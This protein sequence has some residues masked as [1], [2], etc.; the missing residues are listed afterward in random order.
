MRAVV[1]HIWGRGTFGYES[2]PH[3]GMD[4]CFLYCRK[5]EVPAVLRA[6]GLDPGPGI[7][8]ASTGLNVSELEGEGLLGQ[9]GRQIMM[10]WAMEAFT[11]PE[12]IDNSI[13]Y[14]ER[15]DMFH[16]RFLQGFRMINIGLLRD[17]DL[18][19]IGSRILRPVSNGTA[20]QRANTY[21][22]RTPDYMI[23]TS[24]AYHPGTFGDQQ[25]IWTAT[26]SEEVSLFTTHPAK[27]FRIGDTI[28]N[29]PGYWVGNGRLPHCVQHKN[30]VLCMYALDDGLGLLEPEVA[31]FTHAYFPMD[32][33]ADVEIDGRFAFARHRNTLVA[34]IARY[35]LGFAEGSRDDLIQTGVDGYWIFE[36]STVAKEGGNEA[37]KE[38]IREN[39]IVC[40]DRTLQYASGGESLQVTF[41]GEFRV[42][43]ALVDTE[44][45]RFDSPYALCPRKPKLITISCDGHVLELDF[46]NRLRASRSSTT[47]PTHPE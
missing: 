1:E 19:P 28:G 6:I 24:Q 21:T 13:R 4:L 41:G 25:H 46:Y 15:N 44:Y 29:S 3:Q 22:Y 20:I 39:T 45:E 33:L 10:Q 26:L 35:P 16:N 14:I 7:I 30:I 17:Y 8:R 37:F 11:N 40:S 38:R 12:V 47:V 9:A 31:E 5:Y 23:A 36:A 43:G 42:N 32:K 18:L 34:F 2:P 27:P